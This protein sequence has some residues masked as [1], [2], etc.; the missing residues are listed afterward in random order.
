VA[1][2]RLRKSSGFDALDQAARVA[3]SACR[4]KP[5]TQG[6]RPVQSWMNMQYVWTLE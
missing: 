3:I 1:D 5:A 2:S 4:F 6:G